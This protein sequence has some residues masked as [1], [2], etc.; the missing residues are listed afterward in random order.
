MS[1]PGRLA[2]GT[3]ILTPSHHL[4]CFSGYACLSVDRSCAGCQTTRA[5]HTTVM[6]SNLFERISEFLESRRPWYKLPRVLAMPR[7]IEIRNELREKNLH[8]TE[9][10]PLQRQA[11]PP[12]LDPKLREERTIDGTHNDLNYPQMGS[13]GRRFGRNVPLEHVYPDTPHLLH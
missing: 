4:H 7:L 8:D 10:P 2:I 12:D 5:T 9:E 11:V 13:C 1:G 3:H 6:P